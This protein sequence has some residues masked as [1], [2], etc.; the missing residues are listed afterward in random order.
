MAHCV[1]SRLI[2]TEV[3]VRLACIVHAH[4]APC[5]LNG[6]PAAP[7]PMHCSDEP[8]RDAVIKS[9]ELRTHRQRTVVIHRGSLDAKKQHATGR[10]SFDCWCEPEILVGE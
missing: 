3:G 10:T 4:I 1:V 2:D 7:G 6:D 8:G 9:W 5:P